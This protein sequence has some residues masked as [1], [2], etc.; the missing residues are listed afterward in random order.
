MPTSS[1]FR[2]TIGNKLVG[3]IAALLIISVASLVL[4]ATRMF[5]E[6]NTSMIQQMNADKASSLALQTREG[7]HNLTEKMS[8]I[9]TTLLQES[10][11]PQVKE[12]ITAEY[13]SKDPDFV[14]LVIQKESVNGTFETVQS[15][16]SKEQKAADA[17]GVKILESMAHEKDY[18]PAQVAKGEV[19][20]LTF[21]F[22]DGTFGLSLSIP[23]IDVAG[24]NGTQFSHIV[25]AFLK[26]SK[27]IK[28]FG[29]SD[30][31]NTFLVDR[32]G[33][34]LA[35]PDA[36]RATAGEN[37]SQL[38]IV[39]I[40]LE[41]KANNEQTRYFD[42]NANEWKLGA[43]R[44]VGFGGLGV[45]AEVPEAKAFEAAQ[46]VRHRSMLVAFIILCLAFLTG[47]LYSGTI[48]RPIKSLVEAARRISAGDFAINLKHRGRDEIATLSIAF[49][50][51]ALGLEERDRVKETFNKFHNKE[52]ADKLL[53]GEVKLGG[54]R[55]EA[56]VFFSDV[57][58]F[59]ALSE[60]MEP[61]QVVEM[62]NEYM[63]RMV[64]V[65]RS[66]GG[67]VDK[68]VGDAIMALWGVPITGEDDTYRA[69]RACLAMREDLA[70]L[71][72]L[73]IARGQPVLKIGMG[74]NTGPLIAGNIGSDEKMEY[75]VIGDAVNL[76]SRIES[77]T[78]EY[79]TD[80]LISKRVF[81][82]VGSR[83][84]L[85]NCASAK[86][87]GKA[88]AI[89]IYKV[90]GF[91]DENNQPVIIET[92]YSTYAAEKSDKVVHEAIAVVA[93]T[94]VTPPPFTQ[95]KKR[96]LK[97]ASTLCSTE[98]DKTFAGAK[99]PALF[100]RKRQSVISVAPLQI[101]DK[102][103]GQKQEIILL[104]VQSEVLV[105]S[106]TPPPFNRVIQVIK[107]W[108]LQMG[109]EAV[110][111]FSTEEILN[112][113]NAQEFSSSMMIAPSGLGPWTQVGEH[114]EFGRTR[115]STGIAA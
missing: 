45:I 57:R 47:Y 73:R 9:G 95:T 108:Y 90:R 49:N 75:T 96:S 32:R 53:S 55:K 71:N 76:A 2:L 7:L 20:I 59:T 103:Q 105:K 110:G 38:E 60:S 6:D 91:V 112:G 56:T 104:P 85:E 17:G 100:G 94:S 64:R 62:L 41:G 35:H 16:F 13:F 102:V 11:T 1:F 86:V 58:G 51:M 18:S 92:P 37:V 33:K 14:G 39:K 82:Q 99:I 77:M 80:L 98:E 101:Q 5:S 72:D 42:P 12:Q 46:K 15:V 63:T 27:F 89:E 93:Q 31:V 74:L 44:V 87:K 68:Y 69:V 67:I 23:F 26:Q 81:E 54:E 65:I 107:D 4:L 97:K 28:A 43:F 8:V 109:S 70:K 115:L 24:S 84:I 21:K 10:L 106:V 25:T 52:I 83:F 79:G 3:L 50:E 40:L 22:P 30:I 48:T 66:H 29:E 34:L 19:Q 111:P 88:N 114:S 61:E 113:L 36:A 78:K